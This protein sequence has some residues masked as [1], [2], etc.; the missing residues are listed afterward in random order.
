MKLFL[1]IFFCTLLWSCNSWQCG[2]GARTVLQ[3]TDTLVTIEQWQGIVH[4]VTCQDIEVK[5]TFTR[6]PNKDTG[7]Y[8]MTQHCQDNGNT[9]GEE[10]SWRIKHGR[11]LQ[12]ELV[13]RNGGT[14]R[15]Y[16]VKNNRLMELDADNKEVS[17]YF[18]EKVD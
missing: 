13:G 10:G 17:S 3:G 18:L 8:R 11:Q 4:A 16:H 12:Y 15:Y 14:A 5:I 1:L 7:T 2:K 6:R 9:F